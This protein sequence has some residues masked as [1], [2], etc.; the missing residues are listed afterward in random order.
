MEDGRRQIGRR[1]K[2]EGRRK[3]G[4]GGDCDRQNRQRAEFL[5][6]SPHPLLPPS[7][8]FLGENEIALGVRG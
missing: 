1:Q 8:E 6:F 4:R 3:I 5:R 7:F 2:A